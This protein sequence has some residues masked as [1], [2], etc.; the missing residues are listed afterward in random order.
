MDS[1]KRISEVGIFLC[2][3]FII[4]EMCCMVCVQFFAS[5]SENNVVCHSVAVKPCCHFVQFRPNGKDK[6]C[7]VNYR[8][9]VSIW[10][11]YMVQNIFFSH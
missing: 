6:I 5:G 10:S 3:R 8:A 11:I 2:I 4:I 9:E 7:N 1:K